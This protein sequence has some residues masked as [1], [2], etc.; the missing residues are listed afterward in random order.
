MLG[1]TLSA[2]NT[3]AVLFCTKLSF[4]LLI[5][6]FAYAA[7]LSSARL[8]WSSSAEALRVV[9]LAVQV[10]PHAS[11]GFP[12]ASLIPRVTTIW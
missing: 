8:M 7:P 9:K 12:R 6:A 10:P 4:L 1:C 5:P 11:I 3:S 2:V